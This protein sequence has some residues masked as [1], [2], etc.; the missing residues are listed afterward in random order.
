MMEMTP[1]NGPNPK[2]AISRGLL[3]ISSSASLVSDMSA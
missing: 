2:Q 3:V 1:M